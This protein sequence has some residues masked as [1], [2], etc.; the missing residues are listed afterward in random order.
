MN[1]L[2]N[3]LQSIK[4]E[5]GEVANIHKVFQDFPE[6][7][8]AHYEFYK[9]I[10][11]DESLPLSRA[12]REFLAFKTSETNQCPY[13]VNHHKAAYENHK[14]D[15]NKEIENLLTEFAE[16]MTKSPWKANLFAERFEQHGLSKA[17]WQ[18]AVFVV[19]YFNMANRLAFAMNLEL[20]DNFKKSCQ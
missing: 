3:T 14:E 16:T 12:H 19:G 4:S 13:C 20:E 8:T 2:E 1:Q 7:I 15:L 18:Q 5:R 6:G 9:K 17:E 11:L 10:I